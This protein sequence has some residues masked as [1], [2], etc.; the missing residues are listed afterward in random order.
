MAIGLRA[1]G[2]ALRQV[3]SHFILSLGGNVTAIVLSLPIIV[4]VLLLATFS[5]SLSYVPLGIAVLVGMLP[6][7]AC[8]GLQTLARE[9]AYGESPELSDQ[10]RGLREYWRTALRAWLVSAAVTAVCFLNVAFYA[11]Q[12]A[13]HTSSLRGVAGPLSILWG[14]LLLS[15]LAIHVYVTPLLQAQDEPSVLLAYR[16]A[17][18]LMVSRP[19]ASI[20]VIPVWLALLVATSATGLVTIVGLALAASLQQ[21]ALRALLAVLPV[22]SE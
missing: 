1:V 12:A 5:R 14:L 10:W 7:P 8:M 21:N 11:T 9:L 13:S 6:N 18:V 16:N 17:L 19:L 15:W 22:Q 3:F 20:V 4:I 2:S